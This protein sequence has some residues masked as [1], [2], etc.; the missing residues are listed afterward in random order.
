[1]LG[2]PR[3]SPAAHDPRRY[4]DGTGKPTTI[5]Y[6]ILSFYLL[7]EREGLCQDDGTSSCLSACHAQA[8]PPT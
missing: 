3:R 1:M 2:R 4:R 6:A 7:P 5:N 8:L